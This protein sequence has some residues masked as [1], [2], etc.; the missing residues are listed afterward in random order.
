MKLLVVDDHPV[1][2][3]GVAAL[4]R[5]SALA[6][7][8]LVAG[9]VAAALAL[10]D[11]HGDLDAALLDLM[12]PGGGGAD[13]LRTLAGRHP[14]LPIVILSSSEDPA[15]VRRA[16]ANGALGYVPKSATPAT[17]LAALALVLSGEI[18]VPPLLARNPETSGAR[19]AVLTGRQAEVLECL[20][21]DLS[22]K[23]IAHRLSLSEKTVKAHVTAILRS[24]GVTS[25]REA[26]RS[27]RAG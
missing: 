5:G 6:P 24:L 25:R 16:L 26:A 10:A 3:E 8:V 4:L 12:M 19:D 20:A 14:S 15:D 22:N 11:A 2:L 17:L 9:D 13:A 21:A 7:E 18:Y 27:V 1:V 23:Q